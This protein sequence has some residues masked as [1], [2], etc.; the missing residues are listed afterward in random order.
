MALT[1]GEL[2]DHPSF[3]LELRTSDTGARD[4]IVGG[5]HCLELV[6]PVPWLQ[7]GWVMMTAGA[8]LRG[9]VEAQ[10]QVVERAEE[11][12]IAAIGVGLKAFVP[13]VPI[14]LLDEAEKR[15]FPVFSAPYDTPFREIVQ[16]VN[17]SL[18]SHDLYVFRRLS[19]MQQYLLHAL[20][21]PNAVRAVL[22]RLGGLMGDATVGCI[23]PGGATIAANGAIP[24][25]VEIAGHCDPDRTTE[26]EIEG[27]WGII[28][29]VAI[30]GRPDCW[31]VI[32][33]RS[34]PL[35]RALTKP[36]VET[37]VNLLAL[38]FSTQ[39]NATHS[40]KESRRRLAARVAQ[41]GPSDIDDPVLAGE[42]AAVGIDFIV[43]CRV[44][45][46]TL[47]RDGSAP[48]TEELL[49][50]LEGA[51]GGD[52]LDAVACA[53]DDR[54]LVLVQGEVDGVESWFEASGIEDC[55]VGVSEPF[56][57]IEA[58]SAA[59]D[60]AKVALAMTLT[61]HRA[62]IAVGRHEEL[63]PEVLLISEARSTDARNALAG[64]LEPL[65][66][67][68]PLLSAVEAYLAADL[69]VGR[70]AAALHLHRNSLRNRLTRA[71]ELLGRPLRSPATIAILH[72]GLIAGK[73]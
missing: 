34:E 25:W 26:V 46:A 33:A 55:A 37:A 64:F 31:L 12:G 40:H 18:L 60:Q 5:V 17:Q 24:D 36:L 53:L 22:D 45:V 9:D 10:R 29:P 59:I 27:R 23:R 15:S 4:R 47:D 72:L 54:V 8:Q 43:P 35:D 21:E 19:W 69:D 52:R 48:S 73:L 71:E 1:L 44:V 28:A 39:R 20:H 32:V 61:S 68:P 14:A 65:R 66:R 67:N 49:D 38:F 42:L 50:R 51:I 6:D 56:Q 30:Q 57:R 62:G 70:A 41:R 2:L 16:Y 58:V 13:D 11:G 7:E 63:D 3:G